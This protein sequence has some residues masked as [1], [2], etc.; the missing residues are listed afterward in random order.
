MASITRWL[1]TE[2]KVLDTSIANIR[3]IVKRECD[4]ETT[5][6]YCNWKID[7]DF[8]EV[9][10]IK[11]NNN[12]IRYSYCWISFDTI[13][14]GNEPVE[15]RTTHNK[16]FV[17]A[18]FSGV[19]V[20]YIIDRNSDAKRILRSLLNYSGR[21]EII[22]NNY[23]ID[24]N[25]FIWLISKVY[26]NQNIL[27]GNNEG[28]PDIILKSIRG[29]KGDSADCLTKISASGES[30][31]KVISTLSFLLESRN[32]NQIKIEIEYGNHG[33]IEVELNINKTIKIDI[34]KYV[35]EYL[36]DIKEEKIIKL[37]LLFYLEIFPKIIQLYQNEKEEELWNNEINVK[38]L[39]DLGQALTESIETRIN[40]LKK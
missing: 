27:E 29:F 31:M 16:C 28:D 37:Y 18:Y 24:S 17:I 11:L 40:I 23:S 38:F 36:L 35:G 20:N 2:C 12:E 9:K 39:E 8:G 1:D 34:S 33:C 7:I 6:K 32:I 4:F 10:K 22:E 5:T 19:N 15:D 25:M 30:V 14:P 26:Y 21:N 13:R 3:G